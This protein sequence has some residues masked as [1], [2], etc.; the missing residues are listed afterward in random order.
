MSYMLNEDR[1]FVSEDRPQKVSNSKVFLSD[2]LS[3][4]I[5]AAQDFELLSIG[6]RLRQ[7]LR[8]QSERY[9]FIRTHSRQISH[10][11]DDLH[12][13]IHYEW[14]LLSTPRRKFLNAYNVGAALESQFYEVDSSFLFDSKFSNISYESSPPTVKRVGVQV[15]QANREP[16]DRFEALIEKVRS[17]Q[18]YDK[19]W[20]GANADPICQSAIE[21]AEKFLRANR[22]SLAFSDFDISIASDG[23]VNFY[24]K[25]SIGAIDLGFYGDGTYS[26]YARK[27]GGFEYFGD[28]VEV[29]RVLPVEIV[30]IVKG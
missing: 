26:Y 28:S 14:P 30:D 11:W 25:N 5:R 1:Y 23:E 21:N 16:Y 9:E 4:G 12:V 15:V 18:S 2:M 10:D 20:D 19:G 3:D 17:F 29:S 8:E 6:E 27:S 24:W 13:P 7:Q 22:E